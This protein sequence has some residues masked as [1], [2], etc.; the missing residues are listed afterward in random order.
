MNT[1]ISKILGGRYEIVAL[2]GEGGFSRTYLAND[3]F[4]SGVQYAVKHFIFS[5][6]NQNEVV[7]AK[8]LFQREVTILKNL[9]GH[10]QIPKFYEYLEENQEF[11]L[12]QQYIQGNTLSKEIKSRQKLEEPEVIKI[13]DKLINILL[14]VHSN[15]II[16][17]DIKP[18]NI[19]VDDHDNLFLI[20]FGAVKEIIVRN[21]RLQKPG[22]QIYTQGY[23]PVEQM[24]GYPQFNSDIYALGMTLIEAITGLEPQALTID[25]LGEVVWRDKADVSNWLASILSKMVRYESNARYQSV[26]ELQ[27]DFNVSLSATKLPNTKMMAASLNPY[28][29]SGESISNIIL[30]LILSLLSIIAILYAA[31]LLPEKRDN[32]LKK[33]Q[34]L[35]PEIA[36]MV[37]V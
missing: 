17:R 35:L 27:K 1:G 6:G 9:N 16:H 10:P 33:Q 13:L 12:I 34:S 18:D 28:S 36:L 2:L 24:R 14:F 30:Y 19:I 21:T 26:T 23:S 32:E 22:T 3:L 20:D 25:N 8:Q 11:Y 7:T 31:G 4:Q 15:N 5:S 37:D 29:T